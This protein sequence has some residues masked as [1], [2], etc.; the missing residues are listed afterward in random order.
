VSYKVDLLD[1]GI[2]FGSVTA[3][4]GTIRVVGTYMVVVD[5]AEDLTATI[6]KQLIGSLRRWTSATGR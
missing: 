4:D 5:V 1:T 2:V 6:I 3:Q